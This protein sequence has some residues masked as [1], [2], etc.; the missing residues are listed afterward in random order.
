MPLEQ[1]QALDTL[2]KLRD[3]II[4]YT[5]LTLQ[6]PDMFPQPTVPGKELGA[7]ELVPSFMSLSAL[8]G[9]YLTAGSSGTLLDSSE[10]ETFLH[11]LVR[12]F[13]PDNEID[14]VLGPVVARLCSHQSLA[15]GFA[16]GDGWRGVISGLEA[17]VSVKPIAAMITRLPEWNPETAS[18]PEF[19]TRSLLG[20][21]LRLG[22]F[23]RDWVGVRGA[24]RDGARVADART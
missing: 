24:P 1:Q 16:T 18:A 5:G 21:L 15:V 10:I 6:E 4:S 11:D 3:L 2:D 7:A 13:E 9:P 14:L 23:H 20:P 19:E 22:V 17:L 8:S 12:R